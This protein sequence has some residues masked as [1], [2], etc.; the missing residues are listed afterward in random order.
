MV[1]ATN[2]AP[3]PR[4]E[5]ATVQS[6]QT[7]PSNMPKRRRGGTPAAKRAEPTTTADAAVADEGASESHAKSGPPIG[8]KTRSSKRKAAVRKS[9]GGTSKRTAAVGAA[10]GKSAVIATDEDVSKVSGTSEQA[11]GGGDML[12][13]V[14]GA[15]TSPQSSDEQLQQRLQTLQKLDEEYIALDAME[16]ILR[17][18][19]ERLQQ[20]E[21]RIRRAIQLSSETIAERRER[22]ARERDQKALERLESALMEDEDGS[23]GDDGESNADH[24]INGESISATKIRGGD[25]TAAAEAKERIDDGKDDDTIGG[26][27]VSDL[28][29]YI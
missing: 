20:D 14:V 11:T 21:Q 23:D 8:A 24:G 9:T 27:S 29:A 22:E 15:G 2:G 25:S 1:Q 19:L 6:N 26:I 17:R 16:A 4:A 10:D 5:T 13:L 18:D 7:Q 3:E 28:P 12:A